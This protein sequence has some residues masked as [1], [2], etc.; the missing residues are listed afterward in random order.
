MDQLASENHTHN[1]TR[2]EINLYR[3]NWWIHSNV[4]NFDSVPTRHQPDFK[5]ALSTMYLLKQAEDEKQYAKWSQSSSSSSWQWQTNWWESDYGHS[6]QRW[7]VHWLNG[8][9]R[10]LVANYSFAVWVSARIEFKIFIVN[11]SVTAD[12]SLLSPTG[13]VNTMHLVP[14]IHEHFMIH[15]AT[16]HCAQ[17]QAHFHLHWDHCDQ[18]REKHNAHWRVHRAAL[19]TLRAVFRCVALTCSHCHIDSRASQCL[20]ISSM[21]VV[22]RTGVWAFSSS[23]LS[24]SFSSS[25]ST[26]SWFLPWCLMTTPWMTPC[27]TP[28]SGAW[29]PLTMSN[30][31]QNSW[32]RSRVTLIDKNFKPIYNKVMPTTHSVKNQR[33]WFGTWRT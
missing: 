15:K 8:V 6:P 5:K 3:G 2:A 20:S 31:T 18:L 19:S 9:T 16:E 22:M 14:E 10:Y 23:C 12:G 7:Y 33:R 13:G 26:S 24:T 28:Q 21:V 17:P 32:R 11:I 30:P 27:A 25:S 29:S 1:A 4:A